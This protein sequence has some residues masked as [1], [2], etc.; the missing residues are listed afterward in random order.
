MEAALQC[1]AEKGY[2]GT[3]IRQIAE[4][5]GVTEGALY[6]HY[7]SKEEV[8]QALFKQHLSLF[9][10]TLHAVATSELPLE[11]RFRGMIKTGLQTYRENPAA[12]NFVLLGP[13]GFKPDLPAGFLYPVEVVEALVKE[14]QQAGVIRQ[15]Q[16]NLVA[17]IFLGCLLRPIIVSNGASPGALDLMHETQHDQVIEDAAISALFS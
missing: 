5:A 2:N 3:R 1:F 12:F 7:P 6:R 11:E 14:G 13:P 15:G 8:A 9:A 16:P 4:G 17:A 10:T